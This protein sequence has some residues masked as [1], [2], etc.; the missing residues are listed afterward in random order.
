L[1]PDENTST[2]DPLEVA[3]LASAAGVRI[4]P[5]GIGSNDGTVVSIEGFNV[6][7]ALDEKMLTNIASVTDGTYFHATDA[8]SLATIYGKIDLHF[9]SEAK[10]TEI[11]AAVA[12][13]SALLLCLGAA[14]S[15]VWFGR[16]V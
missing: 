8:A 12:G 2:P 10:L 6:A 11:T 1:A 4:F 3:K 13:V 5:I 14:L 9:A 16:L 15:L 7:T